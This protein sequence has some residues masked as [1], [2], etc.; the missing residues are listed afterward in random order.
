MYPNTTSY[1]KTPD[2]LMAQTLD[3]M[4]SCG[5]NAGQFLAAEERHRASLHLATQELAH[6]VHEQTPSKWR[7]WAGAFFIRIGNHLQGVAVP[8]G[9]QITPELH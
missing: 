9:T 3:T 7:Q 4:H 6:R 1:R 8:T 5:Q 2:A